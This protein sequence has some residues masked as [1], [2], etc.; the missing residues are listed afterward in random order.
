M[1]YKVTYYEN[2]YATVDI[3]AQDPEE[4]ERLFWWQ[5]ENDEDFVDEVLSCRDVAH[6]ELEV[7]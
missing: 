7:E 1:K 4:A 5:W 6:S 3:E 2:Y